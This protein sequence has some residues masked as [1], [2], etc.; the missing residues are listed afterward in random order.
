MTIVK[1]RAWGPPTDLDP[2]GK[3]HYDQPRPQWVL[4]RLV[5]DGLVQV[6]DVVQDSTL[7]DEPG[8]YRPMRSLTRARRI[9]IRSLSDA[10]D[11]VDGPEAK[12]ATM[13]LRAVLR[14]NADRDAMAESI[15]GR[16]ERAADNRKPF[17]A[18]A[19]AVVLL[20]DKVTTLDDE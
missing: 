7:G 15:I 11:A 12:S 1:F 10:L 8:Q 18:L 5:G 16:F 4:G 2:M 19:L 13:A 20:A 17:L 6:G 9:L 3:D 14:D